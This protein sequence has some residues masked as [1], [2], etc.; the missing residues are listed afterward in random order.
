MEE[1]L[2]TCQQNRYASGQVGHV[3]VAL[4]W[5]R[6]PR[7]QD[8][9]AKTLDVD[10]MQIEVSKE[11]RR[12]GHAT[13]FLLELQEMAHKMYHRGVYLENCI[14][15]DSKALAQALVKKG[16]ASPQQFNP[17]SFLFTLPY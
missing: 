5:S 10:V 13:R 8:D 12:Q 17:Y 6:V 3:Y 15:P 1:L 9:E 11:H 4:R 14:T 7:R 2:K 16:L